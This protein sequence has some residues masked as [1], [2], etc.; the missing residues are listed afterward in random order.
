MADNSN[1]AFLQA[2]EETAT[3]VAMMTGIRAQYIEAG[4]SPANAELMVI[5]SLR[6]GNNSK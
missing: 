2:M 1:T 6:S 4:W 3:A 5:E